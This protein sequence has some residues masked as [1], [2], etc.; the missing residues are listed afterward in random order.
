ME[1]GKLGIF[2]K[3]V[4]FIRPIKSNASVNFERA[5][6]VGRVSAS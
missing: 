1:T 6:L 4:E 3:L 2:G 5:T